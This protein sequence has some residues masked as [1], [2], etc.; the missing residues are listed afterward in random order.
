MDSDAD[1]FIVK[2]IIQSGQSVDEW[3]TLREDEGDWR[4]D[5]LHGKPYRH[6]SITQLM[7][8]LEKC[9]KE[10]GIYLS[11]GHKI[12]NKVFLHII[13]LQLPSLNTM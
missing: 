5:K 8:M 12:Q 4:E 1:Y 3:N 10:K 13:Y 6:Y 9:T 7:I 2:S 11:F